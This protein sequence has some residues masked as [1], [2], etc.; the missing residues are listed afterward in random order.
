MPLLNKICAPC[1]VAVCQP[2]TPENGGAYTLTQSINN[3]AIPFRGMIRINLVQLWNQLVF[4]VTMHL[5]ECC[6]N[7]VYSDPQQL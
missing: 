4:K 1:L 3:T 2:L 7:S 5:N 6:T